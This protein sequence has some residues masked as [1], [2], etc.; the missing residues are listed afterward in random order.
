[1][2]FASVDDV[3]CGAT[4]CVTHCDVCVVCVCVCLRRGGG[5]RERKREMGYG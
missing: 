4:L 3:M 1:M 2:G 5:D